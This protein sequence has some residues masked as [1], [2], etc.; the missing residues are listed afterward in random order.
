[1]SSYETRDVSFSALAKALGAFALL[2]VVGGFGARF[3]LG[4]WSNFQPAPRRRLPPPEPRLQSD[5]ATDLRRWREEEDAALR[6]YSWADRARG[7]VRLPVERAMELVLQR[8][9]PTRPGGS[10]R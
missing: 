2:I 1:M 3:A 5:P 8:G 9:L 6:S 10:T 7:V 4:A